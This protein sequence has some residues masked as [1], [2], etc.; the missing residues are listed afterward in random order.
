M[1]DIT[2][3]DNVNINLHRI[4]I[5]LIFD[6][7]G[8]SFYPQSPPRTSLETLTFTAARFQTGDAASFILL[9]GQM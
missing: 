4:R 2:K 6:I 7:S 9:N 3:S 8:I 1:K 5:Y